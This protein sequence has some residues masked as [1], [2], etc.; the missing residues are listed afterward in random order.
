MATA[1]ETAPVNRLDRLRTAGGNYAMLALD[2]RETLRGMFP[3]SPSG[4]TAPDSDLRRFK[5]LA[6]QILTPMA[7]AI[8]LDRVYGLA[9]GRPQALDPQCGLIVAIDDLHQVTGQ[10]VS[11]VQL[12]DLATVDLLHQ[13]G[14]DAIKVLVLWR[15]GSGED[16]RARMVTAAL[17]RAAQ[18]GVVSV[19]EGIVR[20]DLGTS[21]SSPAQRHDAILACAAELAAF[22]GD[23][24]KAQV[25]GYVPGDVS[26]VAGH[27]AQ[28]SA[29]VGG[30]WVVLSNG[31]ETPMFPAAV[32]QACRGGAKG[33]LAGRAIWADTVTAP[34]VAGALRER[35]LA[36]LAE[37]TEIIDG[38]S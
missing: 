7:S 27:A 30:D 37:L 24:Y 33:F 23:I 34:D 12:D 17:E 11:A 2:Q 9:Q 32:T 31:V 35:S 19:V 26:Q 21:W 15:A 8:L 5:Q 3:R 4:Q 38:S 22:G 6:T 16:E 36:R 18:A 29:I 10:E 20:P 1:A 14:A 28:M 13:V 25:P